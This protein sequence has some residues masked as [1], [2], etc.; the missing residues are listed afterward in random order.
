MTQIQSIEG[1]RLDT[2][3]LAIDCILGLVDQQAMPD[4]SYRTV[5]ARLYEER[6][7]LEKEQR[8]LPVNSEPLVIVY[9]ETEIWIRS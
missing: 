8:K 3:Q 9:V 6:A 1:R 2:L 4:E 7:R 5:L